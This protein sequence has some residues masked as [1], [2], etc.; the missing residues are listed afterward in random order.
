MPFWLKHVRLLSLKN[1]SR[2]YSGSTLKF[3]KNM[4]APRNLT[5]FYKKDLDKKYRYGRPD[6]ES[7]PEK[8]SQNSQEN[9]CDDVLLNFTKVYHQSCSA[10]F[11][12]VSVQLFYRKPA[13]SYF[14]RN[15]C[16]TISPIS[17][18]PFKYWKMNSEKLEFLL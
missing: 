18:H 10:D 3:L 14:C 12:I 16:C 15:F 11:T 4:K 8:Y 13:N 6:G 9:S 1:N 5:C 17:V 2:I 7:C